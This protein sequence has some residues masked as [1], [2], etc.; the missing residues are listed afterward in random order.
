MRKGRKIA[1]GGNDAEDVAL[2]SMKKRYRIDDQGEVGRIFPKNRGAVSSGFDA[3]FGLDLVP[4]LQ[5]PTFAIDP[6]NAR[7][8]ELFDLPKQVSR[9][10]RRDILAINQN[11]DARR[12]RHGIGPDLPLGYCEEMDDS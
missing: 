5:I 6:S 4:A 9:E 7:I 2:F 8:A 1:I 10:R 3:V 11:S 12:R